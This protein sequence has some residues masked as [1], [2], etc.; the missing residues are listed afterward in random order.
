MTFLEL[1]AFYVC[2]YVYIVLYCIVLYCTF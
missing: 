1:Y 2:Y